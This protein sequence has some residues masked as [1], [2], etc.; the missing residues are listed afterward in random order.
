MSVLL[1]RLLLFSVDIPEYTQIIAQKMQLEE[2]MEQ[3]V[4]EILV[5]LLGPNKAKVIITITPNV[6]RSKTEIEMWAQKGTKGKPGRKGVTGI[7]V[8]GG[9]GKTTPSTT[10]IK[11]VLPGIP[12]KKDLIERASITT[13]TEEKTP[14]QESQG[15]RK[16]VESIIKLPPTFI[17][18]ITAIIV[19]DR[20]VNDAVV[21]TIESLVTDVLGIKKKRGDKLI[22]K[23]VRFVSGKSFWRIFGTWQFFIIFLILFA[24][25][26]LALFLFGPF[27]GFMKNLLDVIRG[28]LPGAAS[29]SNVSSMEENE[30]E[31]EEEKQIPEIPKEVSLEEE[32]SQGGEEE[33]P[34]EPFKFVQKANLKK[35]LYLIKDEK[36]QTI[37]TIIDFLSPPQAAKVVAALPP[38]IRAEVALEVIKMRTV[39]KDRIAQIAELIKQKIDYVGGGIDKFTELLDL[40][41]DESREIV[42][43]SI[44]EKY[45]NVV[46]KLKERVFT[47]EQIVDLDD[48]VVR[49]IVEN[50]ET[51]T[52]AIALRKANEKVKDKIIHN[53]PEEAIAVL[54]EEMEF[55]KP[56]T[57]QNIF[58][59]QLKIVETIK[60]LES[61]GR[62]AIRKGLEVSGLDEDEINRE[63]RIN[64]LKELEQMSSSK[65]TDNEKA[66][67]FYN[68][69]IDYY[70]AGKY[71]EAI[72]EFKKSL[73]YNDSIWQTYQYIG[74]CYYTLGN[75]KDAFD[76]YKKALEIN[77]DNKELSNWLKT[78]TK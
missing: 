28:F 14:Q 15:L 17:K 58:D 23:K 60:R 31:T 50:I 52:L 1:C 35:L 77:P 36:P 11:E 32:P 29:V 53:M 74:S 59:A 48:A 2:K 3:Q 34:F 21:A 6:E 7:G 56:A 70:K 65:V 66:F 25:G 5:R 24:L 22:I 19:I 55:G 68:A 45:P 78:H 54:K 39:S 72:S 33:M 9:A 41:D 44:E 76:F 63:E 4:N 64:L 27:K 30:E 37:A 71:E 10:K 67:Q 61:E 8:T 26:I 16:S 62:I 47:F 20:K 46:D 13:A 75:E 40:M 69:G 42:L 43:K 73:E 49:I 12:L 51:S 57:D 18:K 38:E